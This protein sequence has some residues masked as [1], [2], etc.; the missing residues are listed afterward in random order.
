MITDGVRF[1]SDR[2]GSE[3]VTD[4]GGK[5]APSAAATRRLNVGDA[6]ILIAALCL[7]LAGIRDR[8]RTLPSR[9]YWW[10]DEC[11]KFRQ[12][13]TSVPP[14][15][16]EDYEFSV[17]S[18]AFYISDECQAWL[19]GTLIGLTPA[20][21]LLRMRQPRAPWHSLL[22]QP[23][24]MACLAALCGYLVDQGWDRTLRLGVARF[25]FWTSL[26]VL[27][28]WAVLLLFRQAQAE[29]SWIDRLGRALGVGW[30]V[31]GFWSQLEQVYF[32]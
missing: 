11:R 3:T 13:L 21:I 4:K 15:S 6:L 22:R 17:H 32:W 8:I 25:P 1:E 16:P 2:D 14:M 31:A 9:A 18:L 28:V 20:Q 30:I 29:K 24:F 10:A 27:S 5:P 26:A 23:G 19:L 7:G 12:D